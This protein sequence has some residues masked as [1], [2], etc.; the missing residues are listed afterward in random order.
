MQ[1]SAICSENISYKCVDKRK[2]S[3]II[4]FT[5]G[6]IKMYKNWIIPCII[7]LAIFGGCSSSPS[8][9]KNYTVKYDGIYFQDL[10]DG[11]GVAIR[12]FKDGIVIEQGLGSLEGDPSDIVMEL[13]SWFNREFESS[14]VYTI[15]GNQI[16]FPINSIN[17]IVDFAGIIMDNELLLN[18]YSHINGYKSENNL[19]KFIPFK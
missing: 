11:D 16:S 19:F 18:S 12:F 10:G 7:F 13:Q 3:Y 9:I 8:V 14:G 4:R 1:L 17:G 6:R 2:N 15:K 5:C